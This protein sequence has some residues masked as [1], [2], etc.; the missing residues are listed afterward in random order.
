MKTITK[1]AAIGLGLALSTSAF[2]QQQQ[3]QQMSDAQCQ[4]VWQ[5]INPTGAGE[6]TQATAGRYLQDFSAADADNND[7]L[8]QSE[9]MDA[10]QQGMVSATAATGTGAG[11]TG[12]GTQQRTQ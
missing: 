10:C 6:A 7:Q 4:S 1:F 9:F 5:Q 11:A 8:S 3:G 2:A 12:Q